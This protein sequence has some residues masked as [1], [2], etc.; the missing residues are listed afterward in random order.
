MVIAKDPFMSTTQPTVYAGP[1]LLR[2]GITLSINPNLRLRTLQ[3][4]DRIAVPDPLDPSDAANRRFVENTISTSGVVAGDGVTIGTDR[5]VYLNKDLVLDTVK[6]TGTLDDG[7]SAVTRQ[8][9]DTAVTPLATKSYV[10]D[11]LKGLAKTN[12][13]TSAIEPLATRTYV[14][15]FMENFVN[16]ET[17]S[18]VIQPFA[19]KTDVENALADKATIHY[20]NDAVKNSVSKTELDW[21]ISEFVSRDYVSEN[22]KNFATKEEVNNNLASATTLLNENLKTDLTNKIHETLQPLASKTYVDDAINNSL[23]STYIDKAIAPLATKSQLDKV[24]SVLATESYVDNAI[25][26]MVNKSYIDEELENMRNR[27]STYVDSTLHGSNFP[28]VYQIQH[29]VPSEGDTI[30]SNG[31]SL[32]LLDP[33]TSLSKLT[34]LFPSNPEDGKYLIV[35]T[36]R[37][38]EEITYGNLKTAGYIKIVPHSFAAGQ[39]EKWVFS[40]TVNAWLLL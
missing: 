28:I 39:S 10:D 34:L 8:Y 6:L 35:T 17:L 14:T 1:G 4:Q 36:T 12:D 7:Q 37:R 16:E 13:I 29:T 31:K 27:I 11:N 22:I 40:S 33:S 9:V 32:L 18:N 26:N 38:V 20:V 2:S 19:R 24:V 25:Q 30:E 21:K 15:S 3:V 23:S 5:K